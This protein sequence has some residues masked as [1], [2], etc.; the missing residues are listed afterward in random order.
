MSVVLGIYKKTVYGKND[1]TRFF[2]ERFRAC[3]QIKK[4]VEASWWNQRPHYGVI[5]WRGFV[6]ARED[7]LRG[8]K[9]SWSVS[10]Q[11]IRGFTEFESS[12]TAQGPVFLGVKKDRVHRP[13]YFGLYVQQT[14]SAK[15]ID[16]VLS[17]YIQKAEDWRPKNISKW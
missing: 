14:W 3:V 4:K 17:F 2:W 11:D 6:W 8:R 13:W 12:M 15:G 9:T 1:K 7:L 5:I 10:V 16:F